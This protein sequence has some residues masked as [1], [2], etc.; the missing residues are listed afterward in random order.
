MPIAPPAD[1]GEN[2]MLPAG[3]DRCERQVGGHRREPLPLRSAPRPELVVD[4]QRAEQREHREGPEQ[5]HGGGIAIRH[6][7]GQR[8]QRHAPHERMPRDAQDA[9]R[10]LRL[11]RA[12]PGEPTAVGLRVLTPHTSRSRANGRT[13]R[14][15]QADHAGAAHSSMYG[16]R[17]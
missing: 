13:T 3:E 7:V 10:G 8:P 16:A 12:C 4:Q 15:S 17:R 9:A 11:P 1:L 14:G 5:H 6:D 2:Q